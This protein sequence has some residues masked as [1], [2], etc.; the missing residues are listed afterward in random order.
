MAAARRPGPDPQVRRAVPVRCGS[1]GPLRRLCLSA[2]LVVACLAAPA[3]PSPAL[4]VEEG[5]LRAAVI[6]AILRYTD[7]P[8][9]ALA[10]RVGVCT[11]GAPPSESNLLAVSAKRELR[12][13]PIVASAIAARDLDAIERC[14]VVVLGPQLSGAAFAEGVDRA[15]RSS[16]LTVCDDCGAGRGPLIRLVYEGSRVGFE[17]DLARARREEFAFGS[18]ML[19][20]AREVYR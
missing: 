15:R 3:M 2:L 19:E 20:L 6:L 9:V 7:W 14:N 17:V 11:L 1:F 8:P 12:G 4:A 13:L 5:Q 18:A 10:D 16:A